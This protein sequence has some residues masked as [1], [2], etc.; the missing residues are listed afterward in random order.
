MEGEDNL[1]AS[2]QDEQNNP[3]G[4]W[5]RL[6]LVNMVYFK[7]MQLIGPLLECYQFF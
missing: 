7:C 4:E 6:L 2:S 1:P 3:D 5:E